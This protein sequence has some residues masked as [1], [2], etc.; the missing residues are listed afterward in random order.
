MELI[1]A[2][3]FGLQ[4]GGSIPDRD[5]DYFVIL[6]LLTAMTMRNTIF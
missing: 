2:I 5:R 3:Y 4:E 1:L 6:E